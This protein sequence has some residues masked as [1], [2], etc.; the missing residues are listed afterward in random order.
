[1]RRVGDLLPGLAS[2]AGPRRGAAR[3][4]RHDRP[5]S[6]SSRS[7]CRRPRAAR[8]CSRSARPTL[9]RER[10]GRPS[11]AQELRLHAARAA[12]GVRGRARAASACPSCGSWSRI[13]RQTGDPSRTS[14][15]VDWPPMGHPPRAQVRPGRRRGPARRPPPTR[16]WSTE[17]ATGSKSRS[18]GNL[19]LVVSSATVGGRAREATALVAETIRREYYYDESAGV[20]I[21]LEK[22]VR[23][24]QPQ[25]ARQPRGQRPAA[26]HRSA[27]PS[28][29][30]ATTSCTWPRSAARRR[31]W[32]AAA[33]LL[34]PDQTQLRRAARGR[35]AARR[36]LARRARRRRLAAAGLPQP[37]RD[38]GHRGAQERGRDAPPAVGRGAPP[39]PVRGGRR[40]RLGRASSSSRPASCVDARRSAASGPSALPG[41]LRRPVRRRRLDGRAASGSAMLG[42]AEHRASRSSGLIDR[43][44]EAMPHRPARAQGVGAAHL[45]GRRR[46]AGRPWAPW[47]SWPSSS[48]SASSSSS[49]RGA[50]MPRRSSAWPAATRRSRWR[51][52]AP[53]ARTTC[54][55]PSPR[56]RSSTTARPGRR[57]PR[58]RHGPL[59]A[60]ARRAG[61]R[62]SAGHGRA[63][64]AHTRW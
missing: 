32:C 55:R 56:R 36:G 8:R 63:S 39:P 10:A 7:W 11:T 40:R 57:S 43:L 28:R 42:R 13:A 54:W 50:A 35:R 33:R 22:A 18:K 29:S 4:A 45:A 12:R 15:R 26:G 59:G 58:P 20:P 34:M 6:A 37:D 52:T 2:R 41:D 49:C 47:P 3:S 44:W 16:C 5:G 25:A 62:V 17:P 30:S 48:C 14:R 60:G 24:R 61:A 53:S 31:T 23:A 27:S 19:Y 1:M 38:R 46:S 51:S 21:C 64:T 9:R